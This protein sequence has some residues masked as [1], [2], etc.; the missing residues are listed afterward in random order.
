[1]SPPSLHYYSNRAPSPGS[2]P[3]GPGVYGVSNGLLGCPWDK[4]ERGKGAF[5]TTL[6]GHGE[7]ESDELAGVLI[8]EVLRDATPCQVDLQLTGYLPSVEAPLARVY[9]PGVKPWEG[10]TGA[11]PQVAHEVFGTVCIGKPF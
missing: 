6:E 4:V 8:E 10:V 1:M 2:R 9:I 5:L 3:L 11:D 7:G